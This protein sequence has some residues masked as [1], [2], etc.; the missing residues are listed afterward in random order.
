MRVYSPALTSASAEYVS[1]YGAKAGSGITSQGIK[2]A[3][4][5]LENLGMSEQAIGE[6]ERTGEMSLSVPWL[7]PQDG[8][9]LERAAVNGMRAAPGTVLFR[10]GGSGDLGITWDHNNKSLWIQ[11]F[12]TGM[13]T[14]YSLQGALLSAI[15]ASLRRRPASGAESRRCPHVPVRHKA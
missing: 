13:I 14:D 5:R 4:R 15:P 9:I 11:D 1:A 3:R 7:A 8:E 12:Y 6:I 2:G 10:T